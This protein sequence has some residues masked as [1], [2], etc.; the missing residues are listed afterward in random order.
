MFA[1]EGKFSEV[2]LGRIRART[3]ARSETGAASEGAAKMAAVASVA[4][5]EAQFSD[6]ERVCS[7]N[8]RL[9]QGPDSPENWRRL[10]VDNPAIEGEAKTVRIGWILEAGQ[11]IVGFLGSIRLLY[12]FDGHTLVAAATC[13]LAIEP[14]YR[15]FSHLLVTS[16]FRQK[17][18]D[19]FVNSSAT[20]S[21]G[22]MMIALKAA[23]IPQKEYASVLFWV[24][25]PRVFT[26]EVLKKMGANPGLASAGSLFGSLLLRS[27][28]TMR[29]RF[30]RRRASS[31]HSIVEMDVRELGAEFERYWLAES[32]RKPRLMAKRTSAIMRWHF[33][34]PHNRRSVIVLGCKKAQQLLGYV[35]VRVEPQGNGGL[36]RSLIADLM[37]KDDDPLVL[38]SLI[39][40]ALEHA[41]AAGGD[42]LEVMGFPAAVRQTLLKWKP[43][44]RN[45]PACPFYYK[46]RDRSLHEKLSDE[47]VWYASPFDGDSTLWP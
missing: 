36:R 1:I 13:R 38:E 26:K 8:L 22:K 30:P 20:S 21:A 15:A 4:V 3:K 17:D 9:E 5:R 31:P 43:Y 2:V 32:Q 23:P 35:V 24:L 25:N 14:A 37:V 10:W 28:I 33:D 18:V 41:K 45:Y 46:A 7:L 11:E 39:F 40:S 42:V 34:P 29:R 44:S 12:E 27:D 6:F 47:G 16:F 19:L